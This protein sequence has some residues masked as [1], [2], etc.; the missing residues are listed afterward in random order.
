MTAVQDDAPTRI[1]EVITRLQSP[2]P[3][4][5][6]LLSLLCG[7]L[8]SLELLPPQHRKYNNNPIPKGTLNLT[9]HILPLQRVL[10][11][12]VFPTWESTLIEEKKLMLLTQFFCP[13]SFSFASAAAGDIAV[14]AYS[15]ILSLPLKD[16]SINL[17]A[18]LSTAYPVDRLHT[19]VFS[20]QALNPSQKQSVI[21]EDCLR[22]VIAA[23]GK[24]ANATGTNAS[25]PPELEPKTYFDNVSLRS[26]FLIFTLSVASNRGMPL[27]S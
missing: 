3:D 27:Y 23:P 7:P 19:A 13:D 8:D 11:E 21:W 16:H 25:I 17:L 12:Y 1:R 22:N 15:S 9:K 10:L 24:V 20:S 2:I 5:T 6:T 14:L 26:E 4:L 18:R